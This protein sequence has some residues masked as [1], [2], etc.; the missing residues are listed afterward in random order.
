MEFEFKQASG[1]MTLRKCFFHFFLIFRFEINF[2]LQK[3]YKIVQ[4]VPVHPHAAPPNINMIYFSTT[5]ISIG[6]ML[7]T[8]FN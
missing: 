8:Q 1:A 3:S 7:L 2:S 4:R 5:R 6:A